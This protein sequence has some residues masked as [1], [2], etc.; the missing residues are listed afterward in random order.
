L[1]SLEQNPCFWLLYL[2]FEADVLEKREAQQGRQEKSKSSPLKALFFR[3]LRG[4]PW[5]K[6][7]YLFGFQHRSLVFG[8]GGDGGGVVDGR[9][10]TTNSEIEEELESLMTLMQDKEIRSRVS[11]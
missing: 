10:S 7:L 6:D 5:S 9:G 2:S 8:C 3:S 11:F 4:C 1:D